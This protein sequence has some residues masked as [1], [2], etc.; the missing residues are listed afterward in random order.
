MPRDEDDDKLD[1]NELFLRMEG[2]WLSAWALDKWT[3]FGHFTFTFSFTFFY[4]HVTFN[5][6]FLIRL[7]RR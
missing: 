6:H 1:S 4:I 7:E 3:K 5:F 2:F